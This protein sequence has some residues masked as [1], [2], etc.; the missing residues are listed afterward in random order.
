[1]NKTNKGRKMNTYLKY[2]LFLL[3]CMAVGAATGFFS[4][5]FK[6]GDGDGI[7]HGM[8][9]FLVLIREN[10]LLILTVFTLAGVVCGEWF[11]RGMKR[12]G[13][14]LSEADEEEYDR[15]EY[16]LERLGNAGIVV[17]NCIMIVSIMVLATGY[18]MDYIKETVGR[19]GTLLAAGMVMFVLED[20]YIGV[21]QLRYVK[22]VQRIYPDKKG[23]PASR[24]FQK[25]WL[26]SCD[27]A[28]RES[29]YQS[30]YKTY[31]LMSQA[32]PILA[33]AAML[34]HFI[35]NTGLMAVGMVCIIWLLLSVSYCRYALTE[36]GKKLRE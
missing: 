15:L 20:F 6:L 5:F 3:V 19:R 35:W 33:V 21:W 11:L 24:K 30:C 23:D 29:I 31:R 7:G 8:S 2:V 13:A 18:S 12:T 34:C 10:M 25:E 9:G 4:A 27:E 28:E 14:R 16:R 36:K 32:M 22:L 26:E 17:S 1:M